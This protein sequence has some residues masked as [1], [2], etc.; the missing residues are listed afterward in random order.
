MQFAKHIHV[1]QLLS[2]VPDKSVE[3][4]TG[5]Q[6]IACWDHLFTY[7][8]ANWAIPTSA[9]IDAEHPYWCQMTTEQ[10]SEVSDCRVMM[11]MKYEELEARLATLPPYFTEY[12]F[13]VAVAKYLLMLAG[14]KAIPFDHRASAT[15]KEFHNRYGTMILGS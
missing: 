1:L 10:R 2:T 9:I 8:H 12:V 13:P 4:M 14:N 6:A 5:E 15:F 7:I 3:R 11:S